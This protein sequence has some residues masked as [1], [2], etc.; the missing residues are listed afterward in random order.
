[1]IKIIKEGTRKVCTCET[2]GCYFSYEQDDVITETE[3]VSPGVK[4][5]IFIKSLKCPQCKTKIILEDK[6]A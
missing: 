6:Q 2:C 4:G 5:L 1:M 3:P